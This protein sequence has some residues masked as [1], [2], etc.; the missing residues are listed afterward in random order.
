MGKHAFPH[1]QF[2]VLLIAC[3]LA[4]PGCRGCVSDPADQTEEE[5]QKEKEEAE[6]RAKKK[7]EEE[8]PFVFEPL[9]TL[10]PVVD[11]IEQKGKKHRPAFWYKPGHWVPTV[12][13]GKANKEDFVG[14]MVQQVQ[15]M[16]RG[17]LDPVHLEAVPFDLATAREISLPKGQDKTFDSV[18]F[19]PAT[20]PMAQADCRIN[21][22]RGGRTLMGLG[23][24]ALRRMPSYQ[25]HFVVFSDLPQR[26]SYV[27]TLDSVK[28]PWQS[29]DDRLDSRYRYYLVSLVASQ[30]GRIPPLP[31]HSLEWTSIACVLWDDG[32]PTALSPDQQAAMVDWLH[33]GGQLVLS[34]PRTLETLRGSFLNDYLPATMPADAPAA[35]KL[36]KDDFAEVN[37]VWARP[38]GGRPSRPL[39]PI[40]P[41][42]GA[43]VKL[44]ADSRYV[45][46]TGELVAERR[47]GRGRVVATL[48]RLSGK[49]LVAWPH[50]DDFFNACVLGRPPRRYSIGS[51]TELIVDWADGPG[52][53]TRTHRF[54]AASVC[55]LR[56]FTRDTGRSMQHYA[57]DVLGAG[58]AGDDRQL[59]NTTPPGTGVG[60][61]SDFGAVAK[62]ARESLN[63]S[64]RI[65]IPD[66]EFVV[67]VVAAYL[68]VLVPANWAVFRTLGRV[69]W[70]WAAAPAIAV[71]C[72]VL[73]I[74]LAQLDIGFARSFTEIGVL[75]LQGD[76]PRG[77]LTRYTALYTSLSTGYDLAMADPGGQVQ[78][79]PTVSAPGEFRLA[80]GEGY[81]PLEYRRGNEVAMTGFHVQSN[82]TR[83][84]HSEE[85]LDLAGPV[86]LGRGGSTGIE[87]VNRT[88]IPLRGAGVVRRTAS[89]DLQAAWLGDLKPGSALA[90]AFLTA[91]DEASS[92][93][94]WHEWRER[95]EETTSHTA[96]GYLNLRALVDLA[97][98]T[99][100]LAPGQARLV[101]WTDAELPGLAVDPAAPQARRA[102]VVVANLRYGFDRDPEPDVRPR[103]AV[104]GEITTPH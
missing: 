99:K 3:S 37:R 16:G 38:L 79:F 60:A 30:S 51:E 96:P 76:Y 104:Q 85:M 34:G 13:A 29:L 80:L 81:T 14:E 82:S 23:G 35:R 59:T 58:T 61:W 46:G 6:A 94:L 71:V 74:R 77:H 101:A 57:A 90:V 103:M 69:E 5:K 8:N 52:G 83:F 97:Q 63:N 89:G 45:P 67:W 4:V 100:G 86:A 64:A 22:R 7:K 102:T 15:A 65:E 40:Q 10:P 62:A 78:P 1:R 43:Q 91:D 11:A 75:E 12:L 70:A 88:G 66:R 41:W 27:E 68:L 20:V 93:G 26:Y 42:E 32:D 56:Y 54:D 53:T 39:E 50:F 28:P 18:L 25:Y 9:A 72:T 47:V 92:G 87:L 95:S 49:E 73:V 19:F 33:W 44:H 48:F 17:G 84:L 24:P 2:L 31:A 36:T 98:D 55:G 21:T